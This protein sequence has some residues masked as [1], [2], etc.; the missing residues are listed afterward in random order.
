[1]F[2]T[3]LPEIL[4]N[5]VSDQRQSF[6]ITGIFLSLYNMFSKTVTP[7]SRETTGKF[8]GVMPLTGSM[9]SALD[10]YLIPY[11]HIEQFMAI[12]LSLKVVPFRVA[13]VQDHINRPT[14]NDALRRVLPKETWIALA[15]SVAMYPQQG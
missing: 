4:L 10:N 12:T 9:P 3:N 6:L 8:A 2:S 14:T 5:W 1:M 11:M 15:K 7:N 13:C